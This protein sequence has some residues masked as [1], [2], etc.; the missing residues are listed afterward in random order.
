M[1]GKQTSDFV[2][3]WEIISHD[4]ET[5]LPIRKSKYSNKKLL[6]ALRKAVHLALILF[7]H[8]QASKFIFTYINE[9]TKL[10]KKPPD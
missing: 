9:E 8:W 5:L 10:K 6:N 1:K 2:L 7:T 3:E 4:T